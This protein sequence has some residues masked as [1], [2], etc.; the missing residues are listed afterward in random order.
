MRPRTTRRIIRGIRHPLGGLPCQ[1]SHRQAGTQ[2]AQERLA[3]GTANSGRSKRRRLR[4]NRPLPQARQNRHD[5]RPRAWPAQPHLA[6]PIRERLNRERG[7]GSSFGSSSPSRFSSSFGSSQERRPAP[8]RRKI[9]QGSARKRATQHRTSAPASASHWL[10][11][12]GSSSISFW[13]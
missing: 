2:T 4:L 13:Q 7:V 3:G 9:A 8:E 5:L 6:E 12:Y 11:A 10:L 1:R